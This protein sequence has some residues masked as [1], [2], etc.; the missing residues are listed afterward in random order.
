MAVQAEDRLRDLH[1]VDPGRSGCADAIEFTK[2]YFFGRSIELEP[3]AG[4]AFILRMPDGRVD[5]KGKVVTWDPPH[6][7][8]VTWLVDWIEDMRDLPECLVSY[9]IVQ[10]GDAVRLT[11]TEAHQWEVPDDLLSGGRAGWPAISSS[12]ACSR[13][14][15]RSRSNGAAEGDDGGA[16]AA[17]A[18]LT[19]TRRRFA[20]GRICVGFEAQDGAGA[21][22]HHGLQGSRWR[23]CS[24]ARRRAMRRGSGRVLRS[25]FGCSNTSTAFLTAQCCGP[26]CGLSARMPRVIAALR[27]SCRIRCTPA[28][29]RRG[30]RHRDQRTA[31][32]IA[33]LALPPLAA[34][35]GVAAL[36]AVP[37][38]ETLTNPTNVQW[39]MAPALPLIAA[40]AGRHGGDQIAAFIGPPAYRP[41]LSILMIPIWPGVAGAR[42]DPFA[43][44][45]PA[46]LPPNQPGPR[47]L[48]A[49]NPRRATG[50]HAGRV[51]A[52]ALT[53]RSLPTTAWD[54]RARHRTARG[55][56]GTYAEHRRICLAFAGVL[57][58]R[59]RG[60]SV[61]RPAGSARPGGPLFPDPAVMI[62]FCAS[63]CCSSGITLRR[64]R[65]CQLALLRQAVRPYADPRYPRVGGESP[66]I[67]S[68]P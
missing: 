47:S 36:P 18:A 60:N 5:V 38:G 19:L 63:R 46:T 49:R 12:R 25:S 24:R 13:P 4:G 10:A 6:R 11:M 67:E 23:Y 50:L 14:A 28:A 16:G 21:H 8:A 59:W 43:L 22:G 45:W 68:G 52:V 34:S 54:V 33:G 39:I 30:R 29:L 9:D 32:T 44:C 1:R 61:P 64:N 66:E 58:W 55:R 17:E 40:V 65:Q 35:L 15:S 56:A 26:P 7:L 27:T 2:Q 48:G 20:S 3:R 37:G 31:A 62:A 41:I 53:G 42:R 51:G 57:C